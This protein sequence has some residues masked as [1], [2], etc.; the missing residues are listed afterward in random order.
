MVIGTGSSCLVV[1]VDDLP[2]VRAGRD[3]ER[4]DVAPAEVHAVVAEVGAALEVLAGDAADAG[5]DGELRLIGRVPDRHHVLVDVV[6]F[7]I[8][9]SWHGATLC[10]ISCGL[11]GC[12][13]A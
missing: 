12:E 8:T 1:L 7:L 10:M 11:S 6:G 3:L 2:H 4:A 13:S 9:T 5:A